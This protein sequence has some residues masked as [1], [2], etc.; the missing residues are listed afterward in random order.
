MLHHLIE[1]CVLRHFSAFIF[2]GPY[3]NRSADVVTLGM[4]TG[5]NLSDL[6]YRVPVNKIS[7]SGLVDD[8]D[9]AFFKD[10]F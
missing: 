4:Y 3:F 8:I 6:V 1:K 9:A 10:P 7:S 5:F 2:Q